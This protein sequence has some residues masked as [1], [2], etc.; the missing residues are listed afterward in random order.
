MDRMRPSWVPGIN[1]MACFNPPKMFV[2]SSEELP[3][4]GISRL[5]GEEFKAHWSV[6][7]SFLFQVC[8]E[9]LAACPSQG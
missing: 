5:D 4:R 3:H 6:A 9:S 1:P 8:L 7:P 2:I